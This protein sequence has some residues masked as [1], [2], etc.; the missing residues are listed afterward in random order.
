MSITGTEHEDHPD[1]HQPIEWPAVDVFISV[2]SVD[3]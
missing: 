3:Q 2:E 1:F